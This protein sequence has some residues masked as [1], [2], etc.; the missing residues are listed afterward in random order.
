ML[1]EHLDTLAETA[2]KAISNI[3]FDKIVVWENG[4]QNGQTATAN[5]LQGLSHPLPPMLQVMKEI[6]GIEVP[7]Y[8]AKL[9]PDSANGDETSAGNVVT[10]SVADASSSPKTEKVEPRPE[11]TDPPSQSRPSKAKG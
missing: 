1:L 5:F 8:L 2:A 6:G 7:E 4:S 9:T 10:D 11:V 3:K